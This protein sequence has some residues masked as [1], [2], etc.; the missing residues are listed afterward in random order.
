MRY[1]VSKRGMEMAEEYCR[2]TNRYFK[3]DNARVIKVK[4]KRR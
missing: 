3:G 2:L 1:K 4:K